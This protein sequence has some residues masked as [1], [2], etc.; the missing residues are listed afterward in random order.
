MTSAVVLAGGRSSRM[1]AP[2]AEL[3]WRGSTMLRHV[4]AV[5][6]RVVD[7][8]VAVVGAPG[9]V[10]PD[11]GPR[12]R[13]LEDAQEG[14]GPMQGLAV[15]LAGLAEDSE[16][17]FVCSTDLPFLHSDFVR[18]VLQAFTDDVDVVLPRVHGYRQPLAAGY[19]TNLAPL[20]EKLLAEGRL[21]P[22]HLFEEC[23]V[24]TLGEERLLADKRLARVDPELESVVNINAPEDYDAALA[25]P[26]PAVSV[27]LYG[28]L[29]RR[30]PGAA[31]QQQLRAGTVAEAAAQVGLSLDGH[32]LA[33]INGDQIHGDGSVPV[34]P[35]DTVSFISAD[36]GG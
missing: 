10:L 13:V 11:L 28:V 26:L 35:G 31:A 20:V 23:R 16:T 30:R 24:V 18:V 4:V 5:V 29:A 25:H 27:E 34:L 14:L 2:K 7:G 12:V 33:A 8:P 1:G 36:A 21:R 17:A 22:A 3:A 32:V 6:G 9:Q 19:R 15:G